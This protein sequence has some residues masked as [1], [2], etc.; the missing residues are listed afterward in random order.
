[1]AIETGSE[2]KRNA[3][4][5]CAKLG[6]LGLKANLPGMIGP[7]VI[8][9]DVS[10]EMKNET[11]LE[12]TYEKNLKECMTQYEFKKRVRIINRCNKKGANEGNVIMEMSATVK[13][14]LTR[15][16]T[17]SNERDVQEL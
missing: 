6:Q 2:Q 5:E 11:I 4:K 16:R 14:I 12:E 3:I 15:A 13:G 9:Y 8:M 10:N 7:K 1:M 17:Q